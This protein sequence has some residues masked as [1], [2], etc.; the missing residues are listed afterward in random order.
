[1][2]ADLVFVDMAGCTVIN[3]CET[4]IL[5]N[6]STLMKHPSITQKADLTAFSKLGS[7]QKRE[8]AL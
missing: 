7:P 4:S 2:C 5:V 1:M 6:K 8:P 3:Q